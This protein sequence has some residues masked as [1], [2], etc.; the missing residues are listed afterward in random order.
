MFATRLS[1]VA[2]DAFLDASHVPD[3]E[4]WVGKN[5]QITAHFEGQVRAGH[6]LVADTIEPRQS[7]SGRVLAPIAIAAF[8]RS[9]SRT[10]DARG[11]L[12]N[13]TKP[14]ENIFRPMVN[15]ASG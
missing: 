11:S 10:A 14:A 2:F 13:M 8:G 1:N 15:A 7:A 12:P 3:P 6:R 5:V 4:W 9:A